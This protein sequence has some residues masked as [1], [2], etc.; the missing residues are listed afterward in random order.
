VKDYIE[1]FVL[2]KINHLKRKS[3]LLKIRNNIY[4]TVKYTVF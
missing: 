4:V 1:N 3:D 2:P